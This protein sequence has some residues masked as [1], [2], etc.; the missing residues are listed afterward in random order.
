MNLI[1]SC[2]CRELTI[3]QWAFETVFRN[4]VL[5]SLKQVTNERKDEMNLIHRL[6]RPEFPITVGTIYP[7]V[8]RTVVL[9][10]LEQVTNDGKDECEPESSTPAS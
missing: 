5:N 9:N 2:L 7:T 6:P 3:T 1:H 10:S 8:D 4:I